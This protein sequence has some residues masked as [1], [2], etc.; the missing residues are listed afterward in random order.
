MKKD[1]TKDLPPT[2]KNMI[3]NDSATERDKPGELCGKILSLDNSKMH[4]GLDIKLTSF[5]PVW[6]SL[7]QKL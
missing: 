6:Y 3:E 5:H 2:I 7:S 1:R 4:G